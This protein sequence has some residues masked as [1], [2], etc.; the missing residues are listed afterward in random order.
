[1]CVNICERESAGELQSYCCFY[2]FI[3]NSRTWTL[4]Q[5]M[6]G[7]QENSSQLLHGV[8]IPQRRCKLNYQHTG[9]IVF[10]LFCFP[11]YHILEANICWKQ[12][13]F[14]RN[15]NEN[16]PSKY[17]TAV[18]KDSV[19][20][21]SKNQDCCLLLVFWLYK[22]NWDTSENKDSTLRLN[23]FRIWFIL[24]K[25][26]FSYNVCKSSLSLSIWF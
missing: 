17:Q 11:W 13:E 9:F 3:F 2:F 22:S 6:I 8:K 7:G 15:R 26:Y 18:F 4:W 20:K 5:L 10:F 24:F 12:N 14:L 21:E 1:M 16:T 23:H 25:R 19:K